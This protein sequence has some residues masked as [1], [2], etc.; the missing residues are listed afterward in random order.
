MRYFKKFGDFCS[1]FAAFAVIIYLFR[2]F[3]LFKPDKNEDMTAE[4]LAELGMRDKIGLF[5]SRETEYGNFLLL[6]LAVLLIASVLAGVIFKRL[7]YISTAF[8]VCPLLLCVD[9]IK[10]E[11]I[12]EYP[13][14]ILLLT[15]IA[16]LSC[17]YECIRRDR[18]DGGCRIGIAGDILCAMS[19]VFLIFLNKRAG[20]FT[21]LGEDFDIQTLGQFEREIYRGVNGESAFDGSLILILAVI[22]FALVMVRIAFRD[23]YFIDFL[24][25][26]PAACLLIYKWNAGALMFHAEL[27]VTLSI[28]ILCA[29]LVAMLGGFSKRN[30]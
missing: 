17:L 18:E 20:S 23:I 6:V 5:L 9:M 12:E 22:Y 16:F 8:A 10:D 2:Q 13:L 11:Q 19:A 27:I 15:C 30:L 26:L 21:A 24:L 4:E 25:A 1:G 29:R 28:C 7:P 3:M 14:L